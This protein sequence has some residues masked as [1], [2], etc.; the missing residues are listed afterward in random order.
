MEKY[1]DGFAIGRFTLAEMVMDDD[2]FRKVV[3]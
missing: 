2:N 1:R 3:R